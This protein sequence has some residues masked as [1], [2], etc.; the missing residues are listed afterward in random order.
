MHEERQK[1]NRE[2]INYDK[3]YINGQRWNPHLETQTIMYHVLESLLIIKMN[4]ETS[5]H[6]CHHLNNNVT[7][8]VRTGQQ[9]NPK[10]QSFT[11]T[12]S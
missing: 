10:N 5:T 3:I 9:E 11:G 12:N 6:Q 2:F 4:H 7:T 8:V 1:Q